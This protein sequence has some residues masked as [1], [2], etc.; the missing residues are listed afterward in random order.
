M[1]CFRGPP[2]EMSVSSTD[3][4]PSGA[5]LHSE[6]DREKEMSGGRYTSKEWQQ[7]E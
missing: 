7:E 3:G 2:D 6:S 4:L 1:A 5:L